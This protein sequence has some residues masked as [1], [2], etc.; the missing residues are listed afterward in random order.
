MGTA[1]LFLKFYELGTAHHSFKK[2]FMTCHLPGCL[3]HEIS[4]EAGDE[5]VR[6][7]VYAPFL[8][9]SAHVGHIDACCSKLGS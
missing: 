7:A 2:S 4:A 1:H 3:L 6:I 5:V 9:S 8:L